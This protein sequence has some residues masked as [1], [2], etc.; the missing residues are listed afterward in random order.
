MKP[1]IMMSQL[2]ALISASNETTKIRLSCGSAL[3]ANPPSARQF[4]P[5]GLSFV[6]KWDRGEGH[7]QKEPYLCL[8]C[9]RCKEGSLYNEYI[10]HAY[11]YQGD[12]C[13][14]RTR[15]LYGLMADEVEIIDDLGI[16]GHGY[17]IGKMSLTKLRRSDYVR[18]AV[19]ARGRTPMFHKGKWVY[20]EEVNA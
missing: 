5:H 8:S 16:T 11:Y 14:S 13:N 7:G 17:E 19:N 3:Y 2:I 10:Y 6:I 9:I 12:N 18:C 15:F 1:E 20:K 4:I